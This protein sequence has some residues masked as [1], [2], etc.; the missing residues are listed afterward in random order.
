VSSPSVPTSV[1]LVESS[2]DVPMH[3]G[4]STGGASAG[5]YSD[6]ISTSDGA[7]LAVPTGAIDALGAVEAVTDGAAS[8][9]G[10]GRGPRLHPRANT[11]SAIASSA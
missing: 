11:A 4:F 6:G 9:R 10:A 1:A 5:G 7:V 8:G 2:I 3:P